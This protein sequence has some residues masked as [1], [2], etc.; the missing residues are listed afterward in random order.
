MLETDCSSNIDLQVDRASYEGPVV[1]LNN[2]GL[3]QAVESSII[4]TNQEFY[5]RGPT[6]CGGLNLHDSSFHV[7]G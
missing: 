6:R 7:S 3:S 4:P 1:Q 5:T 2:Q